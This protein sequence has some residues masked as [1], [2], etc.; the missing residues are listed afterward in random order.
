MQ[1]G[2]EKKS[3]R[4]ERGHRLSVVTT[5]DG[6]HIGQ[7]L[8]Q[9]HPSF[10]KTSLWDAWQLLFPVRIL[11]ARPSVSDCIWR[12]DWCREESLADRKGNSATLKVQTVWSIYTEMAWEYST[13]DDLRE[14]HW[15]RR[16]RPAPNIYG[17]T[18]RVPVQACIPYAS[19]LFVI[20]QANS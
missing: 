8:T 13:G 20:H 11:A 9:E 18:A 2:R 4:K 7:G 6:F 10:M 17:P 15:L 3:L 16:N 5:A 1:W 14:N 12:E 19:Y